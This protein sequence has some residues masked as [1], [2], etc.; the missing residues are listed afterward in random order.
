MI[1][2]YLALLQNMGFL[3]IIW[4]NRYNYFENVSWVGMNY[5]K[6]DFKLYRE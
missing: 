3:Y 6:Y 1:V 2:V 5:N 4:E